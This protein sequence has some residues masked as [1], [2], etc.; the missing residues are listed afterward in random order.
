MKLEKV[1]QKLEIF[2]YADG[3]TVEYLCGLPGIMIWAAMTHLIFLLLSVGV[4]ACRSEI[5]FA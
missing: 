1:D 5:E 4:I 3:L 2:A